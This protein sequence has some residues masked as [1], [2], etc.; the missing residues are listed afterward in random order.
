MAYD[1]FLNKG[2][3]VLLGS[4]AAAEVGLTFLAQVRDILDNEDVNF[5]DVY[6]SGGRFLCVSRPPNERRDNVETRA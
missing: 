1:I 2:G 6:L 4:K 3:K 5:V